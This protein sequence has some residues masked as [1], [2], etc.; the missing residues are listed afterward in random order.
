MRVF[1][2]RYQVIL[3]VGSVSDRVLRQ[4]NR[5]SSAGHHRLLC[6]PEEKAVLQSDLVVRLHITTYHTWSWPAIAPPL[7]SYS[8]SQ[9][10][11]FVGKFPS[12]NTTFGL[13]IP[14]F[15]EI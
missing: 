10:V 8:L 3:D 14:N 11:L 4:H 7:K 13:E 5:I 12:T 2:F 9:N 6:M 1:R 15:R